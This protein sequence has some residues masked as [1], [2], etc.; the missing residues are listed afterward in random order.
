MADTWCSVCAGSHER[1]FD[2]VT[3]DKTT[4]A[5]DLVER[6]R[7]WADDGHPHGLLHRE[8]ADTITRLKAALTD[9]RE[10][11]ASLDEFA[12]GGVDVTDTATGDVRWQYGIRDEL[13]AKI[14]EALRSSVGG[15]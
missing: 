1:G 11:I 15:E 8:A 5:I 12:L 4:S 6:L 13:L 3:P 10:A 14:D 7:W 9:A 2:C